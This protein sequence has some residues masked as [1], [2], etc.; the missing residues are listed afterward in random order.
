MAHKL[1]QHLIYRCLD[2]GR[3]RYLATVGIACSFLTACNADNSKSGDLSAADVEAILQL[4]DDVMYDND[5]RLI[6]KK[7][8]LKSAIENISDRKISKNQLSLSRGIHPNETPDYS[9]LPVVDMVQCK[10]RN[11]EKFQT[12]IS[13]RLELGKINCSSVNPKLIV[14]QEYCSP[15]IYSY[16][17]SHKRSS[18]ISNE[19][20]DNI[21]HVLEIVRKYCKQ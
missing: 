5:P 15:E 7:E 9:Y 6:Q 21:R 20:A 19:S 1:T 3:I 18:Q 16:T 14:Y 8:Y 4:A 17:Y 11:Y 2:V 10:N 13:Y 12:E